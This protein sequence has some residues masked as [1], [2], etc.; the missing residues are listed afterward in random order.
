MCENCLHF[1]VDKIAV[2]RAHISSPPVD[3]SITTMCSAVFNQFEP[4]SLSFLR[5]IVAKMKSST[6]CLDIIT[7]NFLKNV[8]ETL[9]PKMQ[10]IINSSLA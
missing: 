9:G 3:S 4:V 8:F 2:V 6:F 7:S 1:V 10:A 5:D